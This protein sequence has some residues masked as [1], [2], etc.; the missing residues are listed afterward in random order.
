MESVIDCRGERQVRPRS[1]RVHES[2]VGVAAVR[3]GSLVA[4]A[5]TDRHHTADHVA[6]QSDGTKYAVR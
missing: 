2:F 5:V 1:A 6:R 3:K 4:Q